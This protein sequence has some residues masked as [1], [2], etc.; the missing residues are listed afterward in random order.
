M[1]QSVRPNSSLYIL[2]KG[3]NPSLEIGYAT[4]ISTPRQK[5]SLPP[6]F[7]Q[8]REMI[9][10]ITAKVG[11]ESINYNGLPAQLD[12][13]DSFTNGESITI[14]DSKEAINSEIV[15]MKQKSEDIINSTELHKKL[16]S[17]YDRILK[18]LNPE[19]AEKQAQKEEINSL[20]IQMNDMSKSIMELM[21][22]NKLLVEKLQTKI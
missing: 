4:T 7:S 2:H 10:D 18:E 15:S 5:Y 11:N 3:D 17:E 20:K 19:F 16:L 9:V 14:S 8:S 22:S 1:F 21:E 12:I 6:T 13:A